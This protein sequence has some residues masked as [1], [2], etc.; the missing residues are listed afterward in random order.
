MLLLLSVS[1]VQLVSKVGG[2]H[3]RVSCKIYY[4][5]ATKW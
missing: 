5:L 2:H 4:Q 1:A 3:I